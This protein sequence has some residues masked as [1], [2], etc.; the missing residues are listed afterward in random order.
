MAVV[1]GISSGFV[2]TAPTAD[3][4]GTNTTIDGSSV[5]T[6]DTSPIGAIAITEIGWY[7][8]AG[9]NT[10][11]FEV[12]LYSDLAGV[13]ATRLNVDATNSSSVQGWV[14]TT[15]DWAISENTPYWLAVQMDAHS[16]SSSIDSETSGGAGSDVL[17]SQTTLNDPYGG[18]VLADADGIYAIYAKLSVQRNITAGLG[19]VTIVGLAPTV[20][21]S[22]NKN[23]TTDLG[24]IV[25][26]GLEPTVSVTNNTNGR[27]SSG[28]FRN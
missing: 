24:V 19:E 17:T 11:N 1:L 23:I 18:G 5:V 10:A 13:P 28:N 6:K 2:I 7:R 3:P 21:A 14:I 25:I 16:G 4:A 9:T 20:T 22:D 26:S 27:L 12:G 8:G 15:V